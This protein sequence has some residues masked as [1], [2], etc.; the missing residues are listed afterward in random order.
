[1]FADEGHLG[2][3]HENSKVPSLYLPRCPR[4]SITGF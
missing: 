4:E 1:M 2:R 3:I